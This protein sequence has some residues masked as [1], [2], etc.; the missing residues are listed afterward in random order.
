MWGGLGLGKHVFLIDHSTLKSFNLPLFYLN[1]LKVWKGVKVDREEENLNGQHVFEE[2]LFYNSLF[3][4]PCLQ[5]E[6]LCARFV[7]AGVV[8]LAHLMSPGLSR[9]LSAAELGGRLGWCCERQVDRVLAEVRGC[10]SPGLREV[11]REEM[12]RGR[13]KSED[14]SFPALLLSPCEEEEEEEEQESGKLLTLR[15]VK[16]SFP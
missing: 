3:S 2:P 6:A 12:E 13:E 8:R 1:I 10:L 4:I 15:N 16:S 9:W 5:S 7:R 11:L 14:T